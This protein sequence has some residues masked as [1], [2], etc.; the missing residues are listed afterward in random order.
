MT[1]KPRLIEELRNRI[2]ER[3]RMSQQIVWLG[4]AGDGVFV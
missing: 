1:P 4:A 3:Q 2:I